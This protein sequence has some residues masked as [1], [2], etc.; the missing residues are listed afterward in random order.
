MSDSPAANAAS[1]PS[2]RN[3]WVAL[4]AR[5]AVML[6]LV[7]LAI[8]GLFQSQPLYQAA[9]TITLV[10]YFPLSYLS[11]LQF[12]VGAHKERVKDDFRLLGLTQGASGAAELDTLYRQIYSSQQFAIYVSLATLTTLLGFGLYHLRADLSFASEN[13]VTTTFYTFLGAYVFSIHYVYRRYSTWDIQ[14]TVYLYVT[15]RMIGTQ[16]IAFVAAGQLQASSNGVQAMVAI[17]AFVIGYF[18][19]TGIRWLTA[20]VERPLGRFLQRN[21]SRLSTIDGIS[22]WHEARLRES[23]ID[24]VQNLAAV[25]VRELLLGSRFSA[26]QLM[27]WIDQAL[28]II[29]LP[30]DEVQKLHPYGI[31]TI[32]AF[33]ALWGKVESDQLAEIKQS[34]PP[35][36]QALYHAT[37]TGPNLHYVTQYWQA[38]KE[39][40]TRVVTGSLE[41]LLGEQAKQ[42]ARARST[43]FRLIERLSQVMVNLDVAPQDL[44]SLFPDTAESLIAL[45]G[46]YIQ[47]QLYTDAIRILTQAI[48]TDSQNTAA[49]CNRGLAYALQSDYE[50]AFEDFE[51]AKR[52]DPGYATAFSHEGRVYVQQREYQKAITALDRATELDG[53]NALAFCYRGQAWRSLGQ[54]DAAIQDF[55]R[56]LSHDS[57]LHLAYVERGLTYVSLGDYISAVYDFDNAIRTNRNSAQAYGNRGAAYMG[58]GD[59]Q[60]SIYDLDTVIE[61]NPRLADAY[62]NRGRA[63]HLLGDVEGAIDDL[64]EALRV[65]GKLAQAYRNRA[66]AHAE[67]SALPEAIADFEQYLTL[68]PDAPDADDVQRWIRQLQQRIPPGTPSS[69][70]PN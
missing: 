22:I 26:Q 20:T 7:S 38:V 46:I 8:W 9:L 65:D 5:T 18:P 36:I 50:R 2:N 48:E 45:G 66:L 10:S 60:R 33:R 64:D 34:L 41:Q 32:S 31:Y 14:P 58:L 69:D 11:Y 68:R 39:Y 17:M 52:L 35:T 53:T 70:T 63:R 21:E 43:D 47:R 28:L 15:R 57:D 42:F 61:L 51:Q 30:N 40:R 6:V 3:S 67:S 49:Y 62:S 23:G 19:D 13:V 44:E 54:L 55:S 4:L 16:A 24:N 25:D 12:R 27:H 37:A 29:N 1:T 59:H 56:A